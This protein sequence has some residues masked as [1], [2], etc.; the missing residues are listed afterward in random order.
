MIV[1]KPETLAAI[2]R[3][4]ELFR[5]HNPQAYELLQEIGLAVADLT[6][7]LEDRA[8]ERSDP[9]ASSPDERTTPTPG[10]PGGSGEPTPPTPTRSEGESD[11]TASR[12]ARPLQPLVKGPRIPQPFQLAHPMNWDYTGRLI[13]FEAIPDVQRLEFVRWYRAEAIP[14]LEYMG[15]P[16]AGYMDYLRWYI[17]HFQSGVT[18]RKDTE[19]RMHPSFEYYFDEVGQPIIFLHFLE[20]TERERIK[21]ALLS[22]IYYTRDGDPYVNFLV[23]RDWWEKAFSEKGGPKQ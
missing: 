5:E 2:Q 13:A 3:R 6:K 23:Y 20:D 4:R 7:L 14:E 9:S 12:L 19:D 15:K 11:K 17:N 1:P 21:Q 8:P 22:D 18:L 10:T 16:A